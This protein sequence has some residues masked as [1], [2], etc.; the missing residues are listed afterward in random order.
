[1]YSA[2][3]LVSLACEICLSPGKT[4]QAGK[5]L[6]LILANYA[7]TLD[8]D[9][10]RLTTTLNIGPQAT[11][12]YWYQLPAN[13]LRAFDVF[14]N[15]LGQP[16]Y[17]TQMDLKDLDQAYTAEGIDNYP[18]QFAT[19][20][21][22]A[23]PQGAYPTMAFY[24]PPAVPLAVTL[25]YRPTS[26]DIATPETSATIPYYHDQLSLLKEMCILLGD[27]NGGDGREPRWQKEVEARM[28]KYLQ[29]D[30]DKEGYSQ[31]VKLDPRQ[32]RRN[33]N[34]PPSKK[35]GF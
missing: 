13:Y 9:T 35:L 18:Q 21:S 15:V 11:I 3:T 2:A 29:M 32:F 28:R 30:D 23:P 7:L 10:I 17:V 22:T 27:I 34:L 20:M 33:T 25:R 5:A 8:L 14:Y 19:D 12:P 4:V 31:T 6:N 26:L 16:F 24:P 1:M